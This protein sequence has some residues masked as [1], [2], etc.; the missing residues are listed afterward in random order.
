MLQEKQQKIDETNKKVSPDYEKFEDELKCKFDWINSL[1]NCSALVNAEFL[2]ETLSKR[3]WG[4]A[5]TGYCNAVEAEIRNKIVQPLNKYLL[6]KF[7]SNRLLLTSQAFSI[8]VTDDMSLKD[9]H[10]FFN[11]K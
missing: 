9:V 1:T 3:S 6:D 7:K 5:V 11:V 2:C 8:D 10:S 4:E